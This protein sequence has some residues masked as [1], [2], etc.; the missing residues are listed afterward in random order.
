MYNVLVNSVTLEAGY[1][2]YLSI[3]GQHGLAGATV[4]PKLADT[5]VSF[6]N[7]TNKLT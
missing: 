5:V 3:I 7:S 6:N 4:K 2:H 1:T